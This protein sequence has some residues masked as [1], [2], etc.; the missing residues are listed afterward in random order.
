MDFTRIVGQLRPGVDLQVSKSSAVID[1]QKAE[2]RFGV[3]AGANP[4]ADLD[5]LSYG[6]LLASGRNRNPRHGA[7]SGGE[8]GTAD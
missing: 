1:L 7:G 3:T 6:G 5:G 8:M 4:A 2:A